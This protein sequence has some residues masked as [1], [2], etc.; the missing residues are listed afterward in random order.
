MNILNGDYFL[1]ILQIVVAKCKYQ[2]VM[3]LYDDTIT[4]LEISSIYNSIKENSIFNKISI[5]REKNK[6]NEIYNGYRCIIYFCSIDSFLSLDFDK[7]EFINIYFVRDNAILP[8]FLNT[9]YNVMNTSTDYLLMKNQ[10]VD[11]EL[12]F[13][14]FFN[15]FYNYLKNILCFQTHQF[16]EIFDIQKLSQT[17]SLDLI[18]E[19]DKNFEFVDI[20]ILKACE[21]EYKFLPIV[22]YL[23]ITG[24]LLL[25]KSIR[26]QTLSMVDVY[27]S[28][29]E[30]YALVDKF[31]AMATNEMFANLINL[32][33]NCINTFCD[34]C[35]NAIL[36]RLSI[37]DEFSEQN[38]KRILNKMKD[39]LKN[40]NGILSYLYLYDVFGI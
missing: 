36:D 25:I 20:E 34:K 15:K 37:C 4:N 40:T 18:K 24:S 38:I 33:F 6:L 28:A 14:L 2:K 5:T 21:I 39:Y 1:N 16:D 12:I 17:K 32:N 10:V 22:D 13:S 23:V 35:R 9:K 3:L 31:Y 8:Y 29:K 7:S 19:V 27:K 11:I 26:N 30:N